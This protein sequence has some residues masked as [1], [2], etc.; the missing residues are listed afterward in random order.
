MNCLMAKNGGMQ[1]YTLGAAAKCNIDE[2]ST[3][4]FKL[5]TDFQLGMSLQQK[6][7]DR[8]TLSLSCNVDCT[9][10]SA[11]GHKVGLAQEIEAWKVT[12]W[13]NFVTISF[14]KTPFRVSHFRDTCLVALWL[15]TFKRLY[16][17]DIKLLFLPSN[18]CTSANSIN[19]CIESFGEN[20]GS[21]SR[22]NVPGSR[23]LW[24]RRKVLLSEG[25]CGT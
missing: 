1:D 12:L 20:S 24:D 22:R 10:V 15:S 11:G 9:N 21:S 19:R 4:R 7:D 14:Y 18:L 23:V 2:R 13:I 25:T 16:Y 8:I 5:N 17:I 3:F 6:F